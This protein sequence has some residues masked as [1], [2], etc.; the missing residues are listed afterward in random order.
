M[1]CHKYILFNIFTRILLSTGLFLATISLACAEQNPLDITDSDYAQISERIS[2]V[3]IQSPAEKKWLKAKHKVRF[4]TGSEAPPYFFNKKNPIGLSIDYAKIICHAYQIDCEF[5]NQYAGIFADAITRVGT[6]DGPDIFMTGRHSPAREKYV[7]YSNPYLFSPWVIFARVN[8]QNYF[9]LKD[10]EDKKLVGVKGFIVNQRIRKDLPNTEILEVGSQLEA[11]LKVSSGSGD[12]YVGDLANTTFIIAREG[13]TN[14]KVAAP[15]GYQIE[16]ESMMVRKDWPELVSLINKAMDE[17]GEDEKARIKS[18]W[19]SMRFD[20]ESWRSY[21]YWALSAAITM[22]LGAIA[23]GISYRYLKKDKGEIEKLLSEREAMISGLLKAN[24]SAATGALSASIAHELSQPLCAVDLNVHLLRSKLEKGRLTDSLF[25]EILSALEGNNKRAVTILH[26]LRSIFSD[27]DTQ[28]TN[29]SLVDLIDG[30]LK[31]VQPRLVAEGVYLRSNANQQ[32]IVHV[33]PQELQQVILNIMN[34]AIDALSKN[35]ITEKQIVID[36]CEVGGMA[37][38]SVSD[39]A[40][41]VKDEIREQL[42]ELFWST[43][44]S[45]M[46]LG[47]WL[48]KHIISRHNGKIWCEENSIQGSKFI[49]QVPLAV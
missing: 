21:A 6:K 32:L 2:E 10:L 49:I 16:G 9:G 19:F 12:A 5:R 26:S 7:L 24:K 14:L 4:W 30:V 31:I 44:P 3:I 47:L 41:G 37:Q 20:Y 17:I 18:K 29:I 28:F 42:F 38:M 36:L 15:T 43:K 25:K 13:I 11:L 34:N 48:S 22:L 8:E 33:N 40:G 39:N 46:G 1:L 27:D 23:I 35:N 45:G